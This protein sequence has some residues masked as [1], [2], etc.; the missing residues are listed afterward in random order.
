[1]MESATRWR[2]VPMTTV[3]IPKWMAT[4]GSILGLRSSIC[5]RGADTM[6]R[7]VSPSSPVLSDTL[8]LSYFEQDERSADVV[9][10]VEVLWK[11]RTVERKPVRREDKLQRDSESSTVSVLR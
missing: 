2:L 7:N 6:T 11:R 9:Q 10:D 3:M 4:R 1:M 8:C 5:N